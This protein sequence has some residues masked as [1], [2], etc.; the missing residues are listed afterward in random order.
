MPKFDITATF[1]AIIFVWS[2]KGGD[3]MFKII[4]M[5]LKTKTKCLL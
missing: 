5:Q 3:F 2:S 4:L 1:S